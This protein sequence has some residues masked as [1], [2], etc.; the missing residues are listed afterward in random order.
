MSDQTKK[1]EKAAKEKL[2]RAAVKAVKQL[3]S[4]TIGWDD[5]PPEILDDVVKR[6]QAEG[7]EPPDSGAP[8]WTQPQRELIADWEHGDSLNAPPVLQTDGSLLVQTETGECTIAPDGTVTATGTVEPDAVAEGAAADDTAQ[9]RAE[10]D[11]LMKT[12]N[13]FTAKQS[14]RVEEIRKALGIDA[15]SVERKAKK[16]ARTRKDGKPRDK[17]GV[18]DA[19]LKAD[20]K[21]AKEIAGGSMAPGPKQHVLVRDGVVAHL[22]AS[23]TPVTAAAVLALTGFKTEKRLKAFAAGEL[24]RMTDLGEAERTGLTLIFEASGKDPFA[25]GKALAG[26][27]A[28]YVERLRQ[29]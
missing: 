16:P 2:R 7:I 20:V 24:G 9:L 10:L 18:Y 14:K 12:E 23:K 6:A 13:G 4:N 3:Q 11:K 15:D 27:V 5:V 22:G 29:K 25:R 1:A 28:A 19:D 26:I 17:P 8:T 21:R